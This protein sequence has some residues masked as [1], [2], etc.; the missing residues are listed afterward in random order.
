MT[1]NLNVN[2]SESR[3]LDQVQLHLGDG[4]EGTIKSGSRYP[5]ETSQYSNLG[6]SGIVH[7]GTD[8]GGDFR[9]FEF[10]ALAIE[11]RIPDDSSN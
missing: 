4:E 5:I 7:S 10:S 2:S 9:D 11:F 1:L 6:S 3:E 8:Y